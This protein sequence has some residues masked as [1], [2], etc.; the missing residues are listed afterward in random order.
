M[1]EDECEWVSECDSAEADDEGTE[2]LPAWP[3]I[4]IQRRA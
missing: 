3:N 1:K 2:E 4:H